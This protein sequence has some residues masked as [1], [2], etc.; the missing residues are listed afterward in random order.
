MHVC[1][2]REV[3]TPISKKW[4]GNDIV[5]LRPVPAQAGSQATSP[6][7]CGDEGRAAVCDEGGAALVYSYAHTRNL[8]EEVTK[9]DLGILKLI[10]AM[11]GHL[12]VR[13]RTAAEWEPAI[14]VGYRVWHQLR[15]ANGGRVTVD[16]E[17][18]DLFFAS[19]PAKTRLRPKTLTPHPKI[20][21]P[22]S[23]LTAALLTWEPRSA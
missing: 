5:S 14:L 22:K 20:S 23:S 21:A 4:S 13:Q 8:L 18:R 6:D 11:T 12:E 2:R 15:A 16:L 19:L 3:R 17:Q 1:L 9:I 7:P 10:A